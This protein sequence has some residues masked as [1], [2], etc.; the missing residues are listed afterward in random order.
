MTPAAEREV[1]LLVFEVAGQRFAVDLTEVHRIVDGSVSEH[2]GPVLGRP[3]SGKRAL[4]FG[5]GGFE[6][7]LVV[8]SVEQFTR[9]AASSLRRMPPTAG[10]P[11]LAAGVWLGESPVLLVHLAALSTA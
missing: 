4:V 2:V 10:A 3:R 6:A 5:A 8:D 7:H 1:E 11:P 9:V